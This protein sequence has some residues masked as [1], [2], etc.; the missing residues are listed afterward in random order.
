MVHLKSWIDNSA[1]VSWTNKLASPNELAQQLLRVMCLTLAKFRIHVSSDHIVGDW[2]FMPDHGSRMSLSK[3]SSDIWHSFSLSWSRTHV[4]SA[5][6][7][8]YKCDSSS[9]NRPHWPHPRDALTL[10][11]GTVGRVGVKPHGLTRGSNPTNPNTRA[12]SCGTL[13]TFMNGTG[14]PMGLQPSCPRSALLHG[15]I[16]PPATYQSVSPPGTRLSSKAWL[17]PGLP[18]PDPNRFLPPCS[19]ATTRP[20]S[21]QLDETTPFGAALYSPSSSACGPVSTQVLQQKLDT[22]CANR[23]SNSTTSAA[24]L[25][26]MSRKRN[27]STSSSEAA[28]PTKRL[29]VA[30]DHS[31]DLGTPSCA[32]SSL[33]GAC[34]LLAKR[35]EPVHPTLS[36]STPPNMANAATFPLPSLPTLCAEQQKLKAQTPEFSPRTHFGV[37][38]QLKCF[39]EVAPMQQSNYSDVGNRTPTSFTSESKPARTSESHLK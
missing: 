16:K 11:P 31:L 4:P 8:A 28:R 20:P 34:E 6:R 30:P 39:S 33:R 22:T 7:Y 35:S 9:T 32:R 13:D 38:E 24:I 17:G 2:N 27:L 26:A 12:T 29:G 5:L 21:L 14:D 23:T 25:P 15:I 37:E 10:A 1:A 19:A 3:M 18:Q 36:A